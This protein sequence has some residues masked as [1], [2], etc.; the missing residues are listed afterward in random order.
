MPTPR[1][2]AMAARIDS[3]KIQDEPSYLPTARKVVRALLAFVAPVG[4]AGFAL[5]FIARVSQ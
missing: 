2:L 3:L 1:A 5:A 4:F